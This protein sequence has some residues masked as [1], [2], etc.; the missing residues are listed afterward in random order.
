[1][2][3]LTRDRVIAI[4]GHG[5]LDDVRIADV[6]ATGATEEQLLEAFSRVSRSGDVGDEVKR[7]AGA[8]VNRLVEIL[9]ADESDWDER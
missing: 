8:V 7:P 9:T 6:I 3:A 5:R 1:M 2:A 4:L